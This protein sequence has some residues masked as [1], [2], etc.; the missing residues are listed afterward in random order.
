MAVVSRCFG[1]WT[2]FLLQL[3]GRYGDKHSLPSESFTSPE[4][5]LGKQAYVDPVLPEEMI[6]FELPAVTP[7]AFQQANRKASF[8]VVGLGRAAIL[9]YKEDSD[10]E[11][12]PR[13]S[14]HRRDSWH[15]CENRTNELH[16]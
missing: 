3:T 2:L 11:D 4:V 10:F 14:W 5:S 13:A 15:E 8:L 12:S 6:Q 16:T 1:P 7:S 9:S